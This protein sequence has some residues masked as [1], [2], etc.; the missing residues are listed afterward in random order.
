MGC[1]P[2][3]PENGA[4]FLGSN[5]TEAREAASKNPL[6]SYPLRYWFHDNLQPCLVC[7]CSQLLGCENSL[8]PDLV[9]NRGDN[10]D[11]HVSFDLACAPKVFV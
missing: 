7:V 3:S 10:F 1:V 4:G 9:E 6:F 2:R 11:I 5:L 8:L